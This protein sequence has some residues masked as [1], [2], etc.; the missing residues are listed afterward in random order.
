MYSFIH[1]SVVS[2]TIGPAINGGSFTDNLQTAL[3][4]NIG[5]QI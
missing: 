5:S 1:N 2:S 4:N 3:L